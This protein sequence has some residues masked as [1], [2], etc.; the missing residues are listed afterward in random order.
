[1][2]GSRWKN[3][4]HP[5]DNVLHMVRLSH[6]LRSIQNNSVPP[7]FHQSLNRNKTMCLSITQI[8]KYC[9][10]LYICSHFSCCYQYCGELRFKA[11]CK[12]HLHLARIFDSHNQRI[13]R[14]TYHLQFRFPG[15][16]LISWIQLWENVNLSLLFPEMSQRKLFFFILFFET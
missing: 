5:N 6:N 13:D 12:N 14:I 7:P 1:M 3:C 15:W 4:S 10:S 9:G 2:W 11:R 16:K 8:G